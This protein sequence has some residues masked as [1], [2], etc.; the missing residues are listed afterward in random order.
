LASIFG[1]DV[2]QADAAVAS[3]R[4]D[5]VRLAGAMWRTRKSVA[6]LSGPS[7]PAAT[8]WSQGSTFLARDILGGT[9]WA[10]RRG[11]HVGDAPI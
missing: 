5:L 10:A 7:P 11:A 3:I 9:L 8:N 4:A 2:G 6:V 1:R